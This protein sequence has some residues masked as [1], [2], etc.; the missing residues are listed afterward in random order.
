MSCNEIE[1]LVLHDSGIIC[2]FLAINN[3]IYIPIFIIIFLLT[4]VENV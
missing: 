4:A 3:L 2:Y 1:G